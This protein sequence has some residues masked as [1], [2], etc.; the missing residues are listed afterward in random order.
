MNINDITAKMVFEQLEPKLSKIKTSIIFHLS[1]IGDPSMSMETRQISQE[2]IYIL[3]ADARLI[4]NLAFADMHESMG[5]RN[6]PFI[7]PELRTR[8]L[9]QG[10][11]IKEMVTKKAEDYM[12]IIEESGERK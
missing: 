5:N 3:E 1:I 7:P 2:E 4:V 12:K 6:H 11:L 9:K 10:E 8:V